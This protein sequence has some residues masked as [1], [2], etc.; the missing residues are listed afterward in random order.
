MRTEYGTPAGNCA[1]S[2]WE[3]AGTVVFAIRYKLGVGTDV[4]K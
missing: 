4:E 1:A 3:P 2:H